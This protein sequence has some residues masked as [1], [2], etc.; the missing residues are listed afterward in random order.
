MQRCHDDHVCMM[1]SN[2]SKFSKTWDVTSGHQGGKTV[3]TP[4]SQLRVEGSG[5]SHDPLATPSSQV[6]MF[7]SL[8]FFYRVHD[9]APDG[10]S[11]RDYVRL[12]ESSIGS[13]CLHSFRV[14]LTWIFIGGTAVLPM[15]VAPESMGDCL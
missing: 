7:S 15:G 4:R 9:S 8:E 12:V 5:S 13:S 10:S 3:E 2:F 14:L 6:K 11:P 1:V